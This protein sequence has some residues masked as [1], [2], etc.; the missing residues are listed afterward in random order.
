MVK[1]ET[2]RSGLFLRY[3]LTDRLE[4]GIEVP[5]L[6]RYPGILNGLITATERV[7]AQTTRTRE[8][9]RGTGFAFNVNKNGRTLFT[10]GD[11][12]FGLGDMTLI[13]KYQIL[14]QSARA[15]AVSIRL[16]VKVPSGDDRRFFGSG[17]ADVGIGVAM[18]KAVLRNLILYGNVNGIFPTGDISG[19]ALSPVV[20]GIAAAEY[21]WSPAL[22]FVGQ[23]N[24][25]SSP[26]RNTGIKLLDRDVTEVALGFNYRLRSYLLWQVYGIENVDFTTGAA[27]DFTLST[28]ITYRFP[29]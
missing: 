10:G 3:G 4:V 1:F 23:F 13:S 28:V 21:Q 19:L 11:H 6:Y 29:G 26:F 14:R 18:E 17:H 9:L 7:V 2:L 15:P 16:A 27:A 22:S 8:S 5:A 12:E 20:S 24:Y 25:Y